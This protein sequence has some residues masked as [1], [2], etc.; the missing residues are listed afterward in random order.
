MQENSQGGEYMKKLRVLHGIACLSLALGGAFAQQK[1]TTVGTWKLDP[2]QSDFGGDPALQSATVTI[3]K[4]T[5]QMLSWRVRVVDDKGKP[6]SYSWSGPEDGSLHP[7]IETG[8]TS[9][10]QESARKDADGGLIRHGEGSDGSSFDAKSTI[11]A[12]GNTIT[13][14]MTGKSK[15]GKASKAKYV[16]HRAAANSASMDKKPAS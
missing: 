16:Y 3:L 6:S 12:D 4:D 2:A 7:I 9:T 11:S 10:S 15:D 13:D 5:P 8:K 14:Q 1:A